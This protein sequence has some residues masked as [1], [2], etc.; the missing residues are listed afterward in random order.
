MRRIII[1]I[2]A[3]F[4][5]VSTTVFA[6]DYVLILG[7]VGGEKSYYDQFWSATS[8]FHQ[9]LTQEYGY[10]ADQITFLFEDEGTLPGLVTGEA[11]REPVLEAFAQ[12]AEKVQPS[13]RFILFM[14]G[15]ATRSSS[16]IKFNLPGR[17]ISQQEYTDSINSI[18]AEQQLLVFGFPY[19]AGIVQKISESGRIIIT[20]SSSREGYASQAG[21]G[22]LFVDVFSEPYA[23][24]N[25]D[26]VI[27]LLEAFMWMQTRVDE[28]YTQDGAMQAEHPHLDDN[29][30]GRASRKDLEANGEG[31][32]ADKTFLG[33]RRTPLPAKE[34]SPVENPEEEQDESAVAQTHE[35]GHDHGEDPPEE[36]EQAEMKGKSS[37]PY[38][39]ISEADEQAIQENIENASTEPDNP[40]ESAVVL[41]EAEVHDL[42]ED[43]RRVYSTR[44]V[45]KIFNEDGHRFG[46]I[47]IPYTQDAD[48]VTI[49]HARTV[50]PDGTQVELEKRKIVRGIT[51]DSYTEAGL[52][53]DTRLMY[54]ELPK[55]SD[56]CIIDYAYSTRNPRGAMKGEFWR[57]VYFQ[58]D[59]PVQ[60]Y[61]L[62][63]HVPK[64]TPLFYRVNGPS[65]EPTVTENNYS[66]TYTFEAKDVPALRHEPLMPAVSDFAYNISISTIDSWDKLIAWYATL[67]RE[68]DRITKEIE[69]KTKEILIGALSRKEK[70]KRLYEFVATNI[71]YA[72]DERGIWGIKPY[73]AAKVLEGE[74]G[75]CKGKSTLLSTMLRVA[76]IDSYPVLISAGKA[77]GI[78]P[79]IP[80]LAYF[81]H[82]I[83]AVDGGKG[84]DLIWLDP[85]AQTCA[86]G[87][88]P[89]S[90]QNRWTLIVNTDAPTKDGIGVDTADTSIQDQEKLDGEKVKG[91]LYAFQ[92]SPA[93]PADSNVRH[94]KTHVKVKKDLSVEVTHELRV[95]G[96]FNARLRARLLGVD[97]REQR[98]RFL[99]STLEL[100]ER[101]KVEHFKISETKQLGPELK[102]NLTWSCKEYLYKMG[103]QFILELPVIEYP[104]AELLREE[105]RDH[106][107]VLG[108]AFTFEDQIT[109][110]AE[111]PFVIEM[112]PEPQKLQT[113]VAEI[114]LNYTKSGQKAEMKQAIRFH[115]PKVEATQISNLTNV[116]R[117]AS[118]QSTKRF[119]LTQK[120]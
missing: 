61:R 29:G 111:T 86:F 96:D 106:P 73:P 104:Y 69:A 88:F 103:D 85:T 81:N 25:D 28:W 20:S 45:V 11:K 59:V 39:F 71:R 63:T 91:I 9:L 74:W 98:I 94:T 78:V 42:D 100:D 68:Q 3:V 4:L 72:G 35:N 13:D 75:D 57:Q 55:V 66:R 70:I 14:L 6:T 44:R 1:A 24:A 112:V 23:D 93:L 12:L 31:T 32:L 114:H 8:R 56:G 30:D 84:K 7:G 37:L 105:E 95:S 33:T 117:I 5:S 53:V 101:A 77:S 41:W 51:P 118:S 26:G 46:E 92:K 90:D 34:E 60:N 54:F 116:V 67:I 80:S 62:T 10:S 76:G 50:K 107:A 27:S 119:I 17:D 83:L 110:D 87:D 52:T 120:P 15:H 21:F 115:A 36:K 97:H 22:D 79:E 40:E 49:H 38:N 64:K 108:K 47:R 65:I 48:D 2:L 113:D 58:V 89:V 99:R 82:M 109:V 18:R 102:I 19:S 43:G 16:G